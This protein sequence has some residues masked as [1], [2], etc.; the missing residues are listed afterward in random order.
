MAG[1]VAWAVGGPWGGQVQFTM[2]PLLAILALLQQAPQQPVRPFQGASTPPSGDTAGYWQQRV[3]YTI[4]ATLDEQQQ[5]LRGRATM[6]YVNNSP[7]TLREMY[8]HQYLNAFRPGSKWSAADERENRVRFQYLEEADI[9]YE[10]FTIPPVVNGVPVITD[11]P[12][13]PDS[14]VAHF[15]LPAPLAPHDSIRVA[16]EWEARP[17]TVPRRQGRKGRTWD[18]AQWYPKVAVY[19]RGGWEPNPLVPAG[20]LYGEFGRYDV[21]MV[22]R[23]DQVL[24]STGVPV[25]GDPGWSRVARNGSTPWL[26]SDAYTGL[27]PAPSATVPEGYRAVRFVAEDVHHF[28]WSASPD[29]L[30][31][32]ATYVRALPATRFPTWDTVAINVLYK[33]GDDTTWG[34]GIAVDRTITALKWLESV[35]GPYAYPQLTNV[36]RIDSGGTEFPMMIM[37]GSA[38][39]GLILHEGGHVFTYG[40]LGNNEWRSGWLDEG[41]TSYQTSWA[42]KL[43]PQDRRE[44]PP[45]P[46]R[47]AEGYRV[48]AVTIPKA[49]SA[50]LAMLRLELQE[51]TEPLG[52]MAAE[53][54]E[55]GIYNAMIYSRAELMYG[56][57]RDAMGDEAFR[58]FFHDYYSR[59]ALKHVDELAMRTAAERA[60]RCDLRWFFD[61]WVRGT[62]LLDYRVGAVSTHASSGDWVTRVEV[63]RVGELRHPMPVGVRTA[64]G[65]TIG[66]ASHAPDE[67]TVQVV[68]TQKPIEVMLDPY[69]ATWDWNRRNNVQQSYLI[70][71][72]E[73]RVVYDWPFLSQS[74]RART[75][76]ALSPAIWYSEPQRVVVGLRARTNYL[77]Q[78]D[79]H[80]GGFAFATRDAPGP[81]GQNA[82][83]VSRLQ[84]W[85][86]AENIVIPGMSRPLMG[87]AGA[88]NYLDGIIKVDVSKKW[89][90]SPFILT[91]SWK[92]DVRAYG[93]GA[94]PTEG[95]LLPEQW[96]RANV[97]EVGGKVSATSPIFSDSGYTILRARLGVGL[98]AG[99]ATVDTTVANMKAG[100]YARAEG[101]AGRVTPIRGK[102]TLLKLRAYGGITGGRPP[103]Q[104]AVFASSQDP[105][106]TF[107]NDFYRP[108]GAVL[109]QGGPGENFIPAGGAGL[110]GIT[111]NLGLTKVIAANGELSERIAAGKGPWGA[112]ALWLNIFGDVGG[113]SSRYVTLA[114]NFLADAGAG[115]AARG[116]FYDRAIAVRLDLPV[117][118]NQTGF[119]AGRSRGLRGNGS[120]GARWVVSVGE[121]W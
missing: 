102:R 91:P 80:D 15:K 27:E 5:Q 81:G 16:F 6:V 111:P 24:A 78:V 35:W 64:S 23:D 1:N 33:P 89:D 56:H 106:E 69:H 72:P 3:G 118:V 62:G 49:D 9:G 113:G 108:R 74:D 95:L 53:F 68:T 13:A 25:S 30:Y 60:C 84:L 18:F 8:V 31:E 38:S 83:V 48:N 34:K 103:L 110:R 11:Y 40:I 73:P 58:A 98:A 44:E 101:S 54:N 114:D 100:A 39:Q 97:T 37:D 41:L 82:G 36:H 85:A 109:K 29:Y 7:D 86:R 61:E 87:Y 22:V 63:G 105:F 121:I 119:A 52:T 66:R 94:Y 57:L 32:G 12:G 117:I 14:T 75:I 116:E 47:L 93:T 71:I 19:D 76:V 20:E 26:A 96:T 46:A 2:T 55:F 104:R 10:R 4:V 51:R 43:T 112:G 45:P 115:I 79:L 42:Q 92:L 21:T 107:T 59:W 77:S 99:T 88:A 65:W 120:F 90:L 50:G 70:T 17:S 67:Q 28:A